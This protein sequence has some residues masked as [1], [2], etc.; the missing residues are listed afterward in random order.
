MTIL[1]FETQLLNGLKKDFNI[2]T[3]KHNETIRI[4]IKQYIKG[5]ITKNNMLDILK[6]FAKE[7][8]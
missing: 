1:M 2:T 4:L 8:A 6:G 7:N 3:A 5:E